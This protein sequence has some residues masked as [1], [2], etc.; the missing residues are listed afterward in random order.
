M[1]KIAKLVTLALACVLMI[2]VI[3]GMTVSAANTDTTGLSIKGKNVA[4]NAATQLCVAVNGVDATNK[5]S[6]AMLFWDY[7]PGSN[8]TAESATSKQIGADV[9]DGVYYFLS[10]GVDA[11][12][13][14]AKIYFAPALVENDEITDIGTVS[15]GYSIVDYAIQRLTE[16]DGSAAQANLYYQLIRYC[17]A[18]YDVF[19]GYTENGFVMTENGT[20]GS[21]GASVIGATRNDTVLIRA[22]AKNSNGEYFLYWM[23][24]NHAIVSNERVVAVKADKALS[25]YTAVYGNKRDSLYIDT[26]DF[27]ALSNGEDGLLFTPENPGTVNT[28]I[29][30]TVHGYKYSNNVN[31]TYGN[32]TVSLCYSLQYAKVTKT[33]YEGA[34]EF[35]TGYY[36]EKGTVVKNYT[37]DEQAKA[38]IVTDEKTGDKA[39]SSTK[40]AADNGMNFTFTNPAKLY[41]N[42]F[43]FD[44]SVDEYATGTPIQVSFSNG[45]FDFA[46]FSININK[47]GAGNV[48][49]NLSTV[50]ATDN[51][52]YNGIKVANATKNRRIGTF[53]YAYGSTITFKFVVDSTNPLY[54][55]HIYADGTYVG[56]A[57]IQ[58]VEGD[59]TYYDFA[60]SI[61]NRTYNDT[62]CKIA[63]A[64]IFQLRS[65]TTVHT[66]DNVTLFVGSLRD[67]PLEQ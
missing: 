11:K 21:F 35:S 39:L 61:K 53:D 23:N 54:S 32:L 66:V 9:L 36:V 40:Y 31:K 7:N 64:R 37:S 1:K 28:K 17:G 63:T 13:M 4:Y 58:K 6:V 34:E 62:N 56:T 10:Y 20:A 8:P 26:Y 5:D 50:D 48:A 41:N 14:S 18:A 33:N 55:I 47:S 51:V 65:A 45:T 29:W 46:N 60:S 3:V 12:D 49:L 22:E 24:D 52:I 43:E 30:D 19:Y 25:K 57:G 38:W 2:G 27:E 16:Q 42:A 15:A 67:D 59:V 44:F